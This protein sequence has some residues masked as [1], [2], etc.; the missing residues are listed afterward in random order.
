MEREWSCY[1]G[2]Q[3]NGGSMFITGGHFHGGRMVMLQKSPVSWREHGHVT[4]VA[5]LMKGEWSCYGGDQFNGRRYYDCKTFG[6]GVYLKEKGHYECKI[7]E[8]MS[9]QRTLTAK[10][11]RGVDLQGREDIMTKSLEKWQIQ[12]GLRG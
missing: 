11:D 9:K 10:F 2:G 1:G 3:F 4:E 12:S 8:S 7:W 5:R 6:R